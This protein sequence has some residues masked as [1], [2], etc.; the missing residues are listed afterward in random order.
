MVKCSR[1]WLVFIL[2]NQM[3]PHLVNFRLTIF[4]ILFPSQIVKCNCKCHIPKVNAPCYSINT[5]CF[6]H[7]KLEK[8][9]FMLKNIYRNML[10]ILN[11]KNHY[12]TA[13]AMV[14]TATAL[15]PHWL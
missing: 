8:V 3:K 2:N 4:H 14:V 9:G 5:E 7:R 10:K 13:T 15:Q 6:F 11:E 1:S 12:T